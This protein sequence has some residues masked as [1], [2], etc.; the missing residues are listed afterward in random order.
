ML[1]I[2]VLSAMLLFCAGCGKASRTQSRTVTD[3][4]GREIALNGD[5]TRVVALTAAD[6]EI[7]YAVGAGDALV[8]RGEYC[9]YPE[10]ALSLPA[11]QSGAATNVEQI[12]ALSPQVVFMDTMAQS[13]EQIAALEAAGIQVVVSEATDLEGVYESIS[14]IGRVMNRESEAADVIAG[15]KQTFQQLSDKAAAFSDKPTVYF[16]ISP[17]KAGLW[18]AGKGTF[19]DEAASLL[20]AQN[21]FGDVTGWAGISEEQVIQRD[22]EY[23]VTTDKYA[24]TGPTPEQEIA[25]RPGWEHL[26]AVKDGHILNLADDSLVRPGPRL[27]DGVKQLYDFLYAGK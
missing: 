15:M 1:L 26:S 25:G 7:L 17:L 13:V 23:I 2:A 21:V 8:G 12:V 6:C 27:A 16:E 22:P 14:V 10:A 20:G 3:M 18:T 9:D 24:G 19:M 11:V 4:T 5:V